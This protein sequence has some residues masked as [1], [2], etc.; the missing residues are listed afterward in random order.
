MGHLQASVGDRELR[1]F[2]K[3]LES[4]YQAF[5]SILA[6]VFQFTLPTTVI[7]VLNEAH[8]GN[9][10]ELSSVSSCQL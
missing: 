7:F 10:R 4:L 8:L 1:A 5:A 9:L 6:F 2:T 3:G